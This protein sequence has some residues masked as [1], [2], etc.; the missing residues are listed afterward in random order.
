MKTLIKDIRSTS[1]IGETEAEI[2][3]GT[4]LE[5]FAARLPSPIMGRIRDALQ[6]RVELAKMPAKTGELGNGTH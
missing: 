5:F 1:G 4:V 6:S 2:A 3:L